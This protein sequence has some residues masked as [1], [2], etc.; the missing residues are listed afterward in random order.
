[1]PRIAIVTDS[2][3]SLP[4]EVVEEWGIEVI[5]LQVVVGAT[6]YSEGVDEG[7]SPAMVA[8]ALRDFTPVSTSRPSPAVMGQ[9]YAR[10]ADDGVEEI[11]AI[12]LSAQMSGTFES[13][14]VAARTAPVP[15]H[16]V[17]SLQVGP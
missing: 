13:A 9:L 14:A 5:P 6:V 4:V 3:A 16:A 2:T 7:A 1:M 8:Q 17:D 10:L 12:H 11:V 15:V